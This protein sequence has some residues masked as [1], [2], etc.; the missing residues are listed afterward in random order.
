MYTM[1]GRLSCW[2]TA[3]LML[4][5][6]LATVA[7]QEPKVQVSL[8]AEDT[9]V[10]AGEP[11]RVALIQ[12]IEPGWHTYWKNPGDSGAP[13]E[14]L[15]DLPSGFTAGDIQWPWPER[16]PYGPL[17]NF[18]YHDRVVFPI[19]I[20]PPAVIGAEQV[21]LRAA[22]QYL[23]CADICIPEDAN[24]ELTMPVSDT[25][26][27]NPDH[28]SLFAAAMRKIPRDIGAGASY[29]VEGDA[30]AIH[31]EMPGLKPGTI[32]ALH[33]FP[34]Q[35]GVIDNARPQ[36]F[37]LTDTGFRL[38][39]AVGYDWRA[40][41]SALDG[42]IVISEDAGESL[43]TAFEIHPVP[44][45]MP[46]VAGTGVDLWTAVFFA[47][48][49][50][51]ILN[52]MPC[53]F[54]VLSI[55]VLSL[56]GHARSEEVKIHGIVYLSGVVLSFL[57]IAGVLIALRA[58]G[59]QIGW[60]FQLQSPLV[61]GL[62]VY[63]FFIIGL[64]LSGVFEVGMS[65][66]SM[67]E[68]LSARQG[69]GGSFFTGVLAVIVAAPCTAPFMGAAIGFALTQDA[70]S[71]LAIFA[72]LGAGMGLPYVVLCYSPALLTRLPRPGPWMETFKELLAFPMYASA[73]WL[74]WV[75]S[76]QSGST[77]V[78]LILSGL[79]LIA[80]AV[81]LM[82]RMPAGGPGRMLSAVMATIMTL[83]ALALPVMMERPSAPSMSSAA[84]AEIVAGELA[85][86]PWSRERLVTAREEG[87]VFVN[88][89]AAWCITCKV[90]ESVALNSER[91]QT[92]FDNAGV[93]LLKGDWTNED[94]EITA[95]L[96]EYER[97]GV[98]L[99]LLYRPGETRALV[100]PQ[101]LTEAAIINALEG[102]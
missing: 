22:V 34:F 58:G 79:V 74:I 27:V 65:L 76:Q 100:L 40:G 73:V 92:A 83:S 56:V 47:F 30:L 80:F 50:G 53:V 29:E 7:Q 32:E 23:V 28:A 9:A 14:V 6:P 69:Y 93:T 51:L 24:V 66:M 81:W 42:V 43:V 2:I 12:D 39:T 64:M 44:G 41:E 102:L 49:G 86:Q 85:W 96:A 35:E 13:T 101:I 17:V 62:L 10:R 67:G 63:L 33:Y 31:V 55:K 48:L 8:V 4:L 99:Y 82:R 98:P 3:M 38:E 61:V 15:W 77:G 60:G 84:P 54:P 57:I 75:L 71:A 11:F 87:P 26:H 45:T 72:S 1:K 94:P 18:G 46:A 90:N 70:V 5:I 19:E 97:S 88:F 78:L 21:V 20:M 25:A 52:L 68:S 59:A 91:V 37:S 16:V 89:T 36:A 95:A